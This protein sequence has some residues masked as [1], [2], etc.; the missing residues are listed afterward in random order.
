MNQNRNYCLSI[1]GFDP[2]SGAGLSADLKTFEMHKVYGFSVCSAITVQNDIEFQS[3]DWISKEK[4]IAQ[5]EIL[6]KRFPI[7]VFKIGIVESWEILLE[8]LDFIESKVEKPKIILDPVLK[9]SSNFVFHSEENDSVFEK[10][11][12]KCYLITPNYQEI[13]QIS[14]DKNVEETISY[15]NQFTNIFLKGGHKESALGEDILYLKNGEEFI[16]KPKG[17]HVSE[18]HGS[19]CVLASGIAANLAKKLPIGKAC[20]KAKDY[21]YQFLNSTEN[22]LGYHNL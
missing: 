8:I 16:F 9:S 14:P 2:S 13:Q 17:N 3:C 4:I 12:Q 15:L 18:K 20:Q 7:S 11:L 19:G 10:V 1:A 6:L 22:L 5:L 21:T